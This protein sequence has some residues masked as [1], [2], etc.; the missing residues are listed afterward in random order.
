[1]LDAMA[2]VMMPNPP[3]FNRAA[4]DDGGKKSERT[5]YSYARG[6]N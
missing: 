3:V 6:K 1:V 5:V 2:A 4:R